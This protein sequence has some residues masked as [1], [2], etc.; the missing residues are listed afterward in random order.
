[1][2]ATACAAPDNSVTTAPTS[3][4]AQH[5]APAAAKPKPKAANPRADL[6]AFRF[7]DRSAYG[8]QDVWVVYTLRNSSSKKS[9]YSFDWEVVNPQGTRVWNS[10]EMEDNVRPGQTVNGEDTLNLP[11]G[12]KVA[13]Y[14]LHVTSFERTESF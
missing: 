14:H 3:T 12:A 6:T 2:V 9:D 7:S 13:N 5:H 1:M 4:T 10:T 11:D 8:M